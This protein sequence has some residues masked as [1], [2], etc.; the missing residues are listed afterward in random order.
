MRKRIAL[1]YCG[2]CDPGF[3]RVQYFKKIQKAADGLIDWV[4][5]D[6]GDFEA[7][8]IVSGCDTACPAGKMGTTDCGSR[9]IVSVR[10]DKSDPA[11]IV[12]SLLSKEKP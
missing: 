4:T 7:V 3:D 11:E 12:Q 8:L 9:K 6:E 10:D 5:L 1:K 2:G